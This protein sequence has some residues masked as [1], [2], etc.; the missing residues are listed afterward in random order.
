MA[1]GINLSYTPKNFCKEYVEIKK[2]SNQLIQFM[3]AVLGIKKSFDDWFSVKQVDKIEGL[4]KDYNLNY[5]FDWIFVPREDVSRVISGG[6]RLPTTK[7]LG[8]PFEEKYKDIEN[9]S[10]HVFFSKSKENLKLAFRNGWY[11]LIIKNRAIHKPYIDI[12]RFGYFLGYPDCC[13]D[14]FRQYNNH[15]RYNYLFEALKNTK[16]EPIIYCNPLLKDNT[17]SYIYHMPCSYDCK[18]T[19]DYVSNLRKSLLKLEPELVQKTDE[20]LSKPFLVF[21]E[22]NAYLFEGHIENNSILYSDFVFTG[23][24]TENINALSDIMRQGNKIK[25]GKNEIVFYKD[26]EETAKK[27]RKQNGGFIIQ[28]KK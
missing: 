16:T 10:V 18:T 22:Q 23:K 5:K 25:M 9:A 7:M 24:K 20:M 26:N 13:I 2:D 12:L 3:A 21:G 1:G 15:Y 11:P 6:K 17:F 14:F 28:F 19:F 4:C 8:F 27:E